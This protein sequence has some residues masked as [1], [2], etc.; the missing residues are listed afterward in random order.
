MFVQKFTSEPRLVCSAEKSQ[1]LTQ[2]Y[3][4]TCQGSDTDCN[5]QP[6]SFTFTTLCNPAGAT[7]KFPYNRSEELI[8]EMKASMN[9][10]EK[11]AAC[12]RQANNQR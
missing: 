10:S 4:L 7:I 8:A 11:C 1:M 5:G 2:E 6:V 9:L 3:K 12:I